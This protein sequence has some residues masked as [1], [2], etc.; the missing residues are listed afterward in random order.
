MCSAPTV[1]ASNTK[2][3]H[4]PQ[5]LC[6]AHGGGH[7]C[8]FHGCTRSARGATDRCIAH[9]G[10]KVHNT[11]NML[12]PNLPAALHRLLAHLALRIAHCTATL[13]PSIAALRR[14]WLPQERSGGHGAMQGARRSVFLFS[15]AASLHYFFPPP[16]ALLCTR[17]YLRTNYLPFCPLR[18]S[19]NAPRVQAVTAAPSPAARAVHRE[20][21][22]AARH[23]AVGGGATSRDATKARVAAR[24]SV[25]VTAAAPAAPCQCAARPRATL[26]RRSAR[27]IPKRRKLMPRSRPPLDRPPRVPSPP[28]SAA[29]PSRG[30]K[31]LRRRL[32][33]NERF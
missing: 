29:A 9:G 2:S 19:T 1:G 6:K 33:K 12:P 22:T 7:R 31:S 21:R 32:A 14:P 30:R 20:P 25:L 27:G 18:L 28:P 4:A 17:Y 8:T 24:R 13:H 11:L 26:L 10:G 23:T 3:L 5:V 16:A 15:S